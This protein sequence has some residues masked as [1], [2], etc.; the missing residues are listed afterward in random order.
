MAKRDNLKHALRDAVKD[1]LENLHADEELE[2]GK[3]GVIFPG[4]SELRGLNFDKKV[5]SRD[6]IVLDELLASVPRN[7][8]YYLKL[9]KEKNPNEF[10]LKQRI[11]NYETWSDMEWEITSIVRQ[12][13]NKSQALADK[14]GSGRYRVIIWRDGGL[15]GPK[16][17]P[18]DFI[19]DAQESEQFEKNTHKNGNNG[20][21][22]QM[23][24]EEKVKSQVATLGELIKTLQ[25]VN[26]NVSPEQ[27]QKLLSDSFKAGIET[28]AG[29]SSTLGTLLTALLPALINK[30]VTT[31]PQPDIASIVGALGNIIS[32]STQANK[33]E[34]I[35]QLDP[36]DL[37]IKL[38]QA[39][40]IPE[41]NTQKEDPTTKTLELI[42]QLMPLMQNLTGGGSDTSPLTELIRVVGPQVG[43][44]IS[45]ITN[46]VNTVVT[47]GRITPSNK[48][49]VIVESS[50]PIPTQSSVLTSNEQTLQPILTSELPVFKAIKIAAENKDIT[51]YPQ[52]EDLTMRIMTEEQFSQLI[53]NQ[54]DPA[55]ILTQIAKFGGDFFVTPMASEYFNNFI[56]WKKIQIAN[57]II[58]ACEQCKTEFVFTTQA[59]FEQDNKCPECDTILKTII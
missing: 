9:Y 19:I 42:S 31:A 54:L 21:M 7:Q 3:N 27:T 2:L 17:K 55:S 18:I 30:P 46:T 5:K 20:Y 33:I 39:G 45:D 12:Y 6:E 13:T 32:S 49:S 58:A 57:E 26:P 36:I 52:L 25:S 1:E 59:E 16:Y 35:Q 34:P 4:E 38:K 56:A 53:N 14:W 48:P 50:T 40:L 24:V 23:D 15:R 10:E 43:K 29:E 8:G 22:S 51:F 44:V 11:D 28:K 37:L 41:T 47:K